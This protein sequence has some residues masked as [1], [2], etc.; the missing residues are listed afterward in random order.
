MKGLTYL[1]LSLLG[2]M[3]LLVGAQFQASP[4]YMDAEYYFAGGIRL[5]EGKGFSEEIIWNYLDDPEGIP[6]PSHSYWMPLVSI[7]SSIGMRAFGGYQF[8]NTRWLFVLL[9]ASLPS[10]TATLSYSLT[11]KRNLAILAGILA[12]IPGFYL[13]YLTTTDAF[14]FY[15]LFGA[16][17]MLVT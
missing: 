15:M 7:I 17:F 3:I 4:G 5:A 6:H 8:S 12:A 14:A 9:A 10:V 2:L 1:W 13:P 16:L 11:A